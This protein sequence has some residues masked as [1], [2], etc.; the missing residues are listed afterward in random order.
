MSIKN[1]ISSGIIE[2]YVLG[3]CTTTEKNEIELL[4]TQN[5]EL[6][7]AI[8]N[9][10]IDLEKHCF[11]NEVTPTS[12]TND[13]VLE[14]LNSLQYSGIKTNKTTTKV[15]HFNWIKIAATASLLL[16]AVSAVFN[17][18]QYKQNEEQATLLAS[19][20]YAATTLPLANYNILKDPSITPIAMKGVGLHAVCR[21]TMFWDKN[22]GKAYIMIHHL[23]PSADGK[24][25]QLWATVNGKPVSVGLVNDKIRDRFVEVSGV[26][27]GANEFAVTLENDGGAIV[28]T[29]DE[30]YLKG[31]I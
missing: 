18:I 31:T 1:Y 11:E 17:Y 19:K 30:T 6:N 29:L 21:C 26:P 7:T 12:T 27:E 13:K 28:P 3:L 23:L 22:T 14:T 9:F 25:Y 24:D 5:V 16:F 10:E 20:N 2:Q 4:R 8:L 15:V